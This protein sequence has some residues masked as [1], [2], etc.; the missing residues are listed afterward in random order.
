MPTA[1]VVDANEIELG[2]TFYPIKRPVQQVLSSLYPS[3][4]VIGD[5]D[6]DS[7]PTRSVIAWSEFRGGIGKDVLEGA[8]DLDRVWWSTLQ[9][10]YK[11]HVVLP[12]R[13]NITA[14]FSGAS[15]RVIPILIEYGNA[16]YA[17]VGLEV[18]LY[19]NLLDTWGAN[20]HTLPSVA[21]DAIVVRMLGTVYLVIATGTGYVKFDG[22]TWTDASENC[23]YLTWWDNKFWAIDSAGQLRVTSDLLTWGN[24]AQLPLPDNYVTDLFTSR[25]AGGNEIIYASTKVGLWVHDVENTWWVNTEMEHPFHPD[26]GNGTGK[27]RGSVYIPAGLQI[28]KRN[29]G[30]TAVVT[31]M[32]PDR[33]DGLPQDKR[34]TIRQLIPT[35][36]DLLAVLDATSNDAAPSSYNSFM[37]AQQP[38]I[39][40]E[41]GFSAILAYNELGWECR[42]LSGSAAKKIEAARTAN[43]YD[44]YRLWWAQDERVYWMQLTREVTNPNELPA[45]EYAQTGELLTPWFTAGQSNV[46][47]VAL[48][49]KVECK[50]MSPTETLEISYATNYSGT[51]T[52]FGTITTD[53]LTTYEYPD[54][55]DPTGTEFRSI[56]FKVTAARGSQVTASP[57]LL[58]LTLEWVKKLDAR[59]GHGVVIDMSR[60]YKGKSPMEMRSSLLAT[61]EQNVLAEF[62]YRNDTGNSR[63]FYV[64]VQSATGLEA[65]GEDERGETTLFLMEV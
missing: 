56:R 45:Y 3:K 62:T 59:W 48:A 49:L 58:S 31:V 18:Y 63:N 43:A 47:K 26:A 19:D 52:S 8:S 23:Q 9:L 13:S 61:I 14:A 40:P 42:W 17:T 28:Y 34:G 16:M 60:H 38:V 10:R 22:T 64:R 5:T 7:D 39:G 65:T 29:I 6:K 2:G 21:T 24:N 12:P 4:I 53:G 41:V 55:T 44:T 27:W 50:G 25:D 36:N 15:S 1:R 33:D 11:G 20:L 57:D 32:G 51:Y 46:T 54:S 37:Y 35:H 30:P